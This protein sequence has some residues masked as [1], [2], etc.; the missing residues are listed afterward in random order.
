MVG[1]TLMGAMA[2]ADLAD[3]PSMFIEDGKFNG[4]LVVGKNAAAEDVVGITNIAMSLQA[5]SVKKTAVDT[6]AGTTV[7][8]DDGYE[9]GDEDFYYTET[10]Q[11]VEPAELDS[12]DLPDLLTDGEYNDNEGDNDNDETYEQ[13]LAFPT[14]PDQAAF[15]LYQDDDDAPE[16]GNYLWLSDASGDTLYTYTLEFD[17]P[18]QFNN[19]TASDA[20]DDLESTSLDILGMR[21]TITDVDTDSAGDIDKITLMAGDTVIWLMQGDEITVTVDGVDHT[22]EMVDVDEDATSCGFKVDGDSTWIDV[23]DT[24]SKNG[25][26]IGVTDARAV[27]SEAQD[28]DICEVNL[29]ASEL[30]LEDGQEVDINGDEVDGSLVTLNGGGGSGDDGEW[31]GFDISFLPED[32]LYLAPGES[33]VDPVFGHFKIVFAGVETSS[34]EMIEAAGSGDSGELKFLNSDDEEIVLDLIVD[35]T[36]ASPDVVYLG[37]DLAPED[38]IYVE[39]AACDFNASGDVE[40]CTGARFLAVISNEA[41]LIEITDIDLGNLEMSFEDLTYGATDN[42]VDVALGTAGPWTIALGEGV[43]NIQLSCINTTAAGGGDV[44]CDFAGSATA[45][46]AAHIEFTNLGDNLGGGIL[47]METSEEGDLDLEI[48]LTDPTTPI[49]SEFNFTERTDTVAPLKVGFTLTGADDGTDGIVDD[50]EF[51]WNGAAGGQGPFDMAD[52]NDDVVVRATNKGTWVEYNVEDDDMVSIKHY[53]DDVIAKVFVTPLGAEVIASAGEGV[54]ETEQVQKISVGAVKLD[55]EVSNIKSQHAVVVGGP[56]ANTAAASL[57]GNPANCAEGFVEGEGVIK[58]FE[59]GDNVA[60]LVAGYSALDTR[61]ATQVVAEYD[62]YDLEGMEM[63]VS[64]TSLTDISVSAPVE[65]VEEEAE[66]EA[67]EEEA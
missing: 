1:M 36:A 67:E 29:G 31:D 43:G 49:L 63:V 18:I 61:K 5:V 19:E 35:D 54:I 12:G 51:A 17:N 23:D 45:M 53:Y 28:A 13:T 2:A 14:D 6:G 39:G 22:V 8:V 16:A 47:D 11:S 15:I 33:W 24:E 37:E 40:D 27:H 10:I 57:M 3:Y 41:H 20:G 7:A 50:I 48:D 38:R 32:D 30:I 55:S 64:G 9:V 52:D 34:H 59:N 21:Y 62:E 66:E 56:C 60:M 58:L 26:S 25:V 44:A 65:E 46:R 42:D 4:L